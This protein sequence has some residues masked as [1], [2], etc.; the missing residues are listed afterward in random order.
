MLTALFR[1]LKK[2]LKKNSMSWIST[3]WSLTLRWADAGLL[4]EHH[5]RKYDVTVYIWVEGTPNDWNRQMTCTW[6]AMLTRCSVCIQSSL[7]EFGKKSQQ[8]LNKSDVATD[9]S[10]FLPIDKNKIWGIVNMRPQIAY[11]TSFANHNYIF[12]PVAKTW[13]IILNI[14]MCPP[15]H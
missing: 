11:K 12:N 1:S 14:R 10:V 6:T 9:V 4:H 3:V 8:Q 15:P 13:L 2:K 7:Q 5:G